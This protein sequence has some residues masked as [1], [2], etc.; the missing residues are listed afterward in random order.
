MTYCHWCGRK[1][2]PAHIKCVQCRAKLADHIRAGQERARIAREREWEWHE[3]TAEEVEK[4]VAEQMQNL[5]S[6]WK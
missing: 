6:W 2:K 4:I 3:P 5:P 1:I